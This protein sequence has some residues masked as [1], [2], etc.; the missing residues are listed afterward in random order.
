MAGI[1]LA[2]LAIPKSNEP[3]KRKHVV[4]LD[5]LSN[6]YSNPELKKR[7]LV[8]P[9][10]LQKADK[11]LEAI[12]KKTQELLDKAEQRV[13]RK[14]FGAKPTI[15]TDKSQLPTVKIDDSLSEKI[16]DNIYSPKTTESLQQTQRTASYF[17]YLSMS[18]KKLPKQI[19]DYVKDKHF[20]F[21]GE[22]YSSMDT[23]ELIEL[24]K[25]SAHQL[26]NAIAR[27]E[28]RGWFK[29]VQSSSAGHRTL[30]IDKELFGIK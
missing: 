1:N 11:K 5:E 4:R 19:L 28:D 7:D 13:K 14:E 15:V 2:E 18:R 8:K 23:F 6:A 16:S 29:I 30:K 25:K 27:L 22:N 24:T 17:D 12:E 9:D 26:S 3:I 21:K 20:V 10:P